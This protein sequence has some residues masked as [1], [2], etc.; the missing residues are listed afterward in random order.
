MLMALLLLETMKLAHPIL[1][2]TLKVVQDILIPARMVHLAM[3]AMVLDD[4]VV[5]TLTLLAF[6]I[7]NQD[8]MI[9]MKVLHNDVTLTVFVMVI[10]IEIEIGLVALKEV[11]KWVAKAVVALVVLNLVKIGESEIH[12]KEMIPLINIRLNNILVREI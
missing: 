11:V 7:V 12:Q 10:V 5:V 9:K 6:K 4:M 2:V 8:N 1:V 3:A